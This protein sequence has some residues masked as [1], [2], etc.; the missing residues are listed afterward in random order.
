MLMTGHLYFIGIAGHAMRGLALA[1]RDNG[2]EVTG[3]DP[4]AIP[5]G[6]D[7]L[8]EHKFKWSKEFSPEQLDGVTAVIITGAHVAPDSPV[9]QEAQRRG[10]PVRSYA[11]F[12][13]Q[14][15]KFETVVAVAGTHGKTTTTALIAW[16]LD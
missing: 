6:S 8:D 3:L 5:P 7:W 12:F 16:L 9:I 1:A 13:G 2:Y 15:T 4:S 14:L 11:E 10:I